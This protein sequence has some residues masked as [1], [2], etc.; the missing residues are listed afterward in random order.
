MKFKKKQVESHCVKW[1]DIKPL[2]NQFE[3]IKF[4]FCDYNR[5]TYAS[6]LCYGNDEARISR[7][8]VGTDKQLH[9]VLLD[10]YVGEKF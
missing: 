5:E 2:L 10:E 7:V 9:I 1:K 3:E 8:Y 4:H 6:L